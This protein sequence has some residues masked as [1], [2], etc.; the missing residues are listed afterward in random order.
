[1]PLAL[2]EPWSRG[3]CAYKLLQYMAAGVPAVGSDVG[4][5]ADL[6]ERAATV[7]SR[8]RRPTGSTRSERSR[9]TLRCASGSGRAGRETALD[10]GLSRGCRPARRVR[11]ARRGGQQRIEI[12]RR[13]ALDREV[14]RARQRRAAA[15]PGASSASAIAAASAASSPT[16]HER[17][18]SPALEDLGRP[19]RT[20]GAHTG[21]PHASASI[22][23]LGQTL[24]ARA[25]GE[26]RTLRHPRER[27]R[28]EA[29]QRDVA[30]D[31]ELGREPLERA[32]LRSLA[33]ITSRAGAW[34]ATARTRA[35]ARRSP[36]GA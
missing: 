31:P 7:C 17:P 2:D 13:D 11:V 36:S 33:Q 4:M 26:H 24:P 15:S 25:Q 28:D 35:A 23:T 22:S 32:A 19:A 8:A 12:A 10:Y 34:P 14:A 16:G 9:A 18:E 21:P 29:R 1:M 27:V 20:I 6:I 3:K 5:N 30:L